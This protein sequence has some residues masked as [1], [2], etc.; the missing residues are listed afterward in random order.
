[1]AGEMKT[2]TALENGEVSISSGLHRREKSVDLAERVRF[3]IKEG[4][5][6]LDVKSAEKRA[7]F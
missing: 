5:L 1:M 7:F 4:A 2:E 6:C 3:I